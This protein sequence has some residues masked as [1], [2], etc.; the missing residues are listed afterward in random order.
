[1]TELRSHAAEFEKAGA[2]LVVIGNG[3]PAM[4]KQFAE[5][6]DLPKSM[7]LLTDPSLQAYQAANLKRGLWQTIG[8]QSWLPYLQTLARG[9]RQ[10]RKAGDLL[11]QGGALV[12]AAGGEVLYRHVSNHPGD[13]APARKLLKALR[14]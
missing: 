6:N 9:F 11:Q 4:A 8:P 10:K 3:W 14:A 1:M 5:R 7:T 13:Q 2:N 12:L